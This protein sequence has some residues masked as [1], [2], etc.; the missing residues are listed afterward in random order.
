MIT[1]WREHLERA[2]RRKRS[3]QATFLNKEGDPHSPAADVLA[4]LAKFCRAHRT[5]AVFSS[6]R[7]VFDPYA[8]ARADGRREVWLR[9]QSHLR[10]NDRQLERIQDH[11]ES[12]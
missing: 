11:A 6:I 10:L 3:Y 7:G 8:S 2:L 4:D 12:E 1:Q 9:I 5:T